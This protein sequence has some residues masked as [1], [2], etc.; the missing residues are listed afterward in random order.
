MINTYNIAETPVN[1]DSR[2]RLVQLVTS[3]DPSEPTMKSIAH[4]IT[5][6]SGK[7]GDTPFGDRELHHVL[8]NVF[9]KADEAYEAEKHLLLGTKDSAPVLANLLYEWCIEQD[10]DFEDN[11]PLF[12]SRGVLGYL[13][14]RNIRDAWKVC[15][16]FIDQIKQSERLESK[17]LEQNGH[18]IDVFEASPLLDF[19]QLLILACQYKNPDMFNRLKTRYKNQIQNIQAFDKPLSVIGQDIFGI[20]PPRNQGNILQDLMGG[21][22]A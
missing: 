10:D 3:F 17:N 16:V 9:V 13:T 11:A 2:A 6:W 21:L 5:T 14:I 19:L 1:G 4:E 18:T 7:H 8:G 22:F 20:A 12:L 15:H